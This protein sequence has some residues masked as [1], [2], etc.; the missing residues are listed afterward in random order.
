[1]NK[2]LKIIVAAVLIIFGVVSA[3]LLSWGEP[4]SQ[5]QKTEL[6]N[7]ENNNPAN[8]LGFNDIS[9]TTWVVQ[10]DNSSSAELGFVIDGEL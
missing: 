6:K 5:L 2:K 1:M 7:T 4:T 8:S 3:V 9:G 10:S